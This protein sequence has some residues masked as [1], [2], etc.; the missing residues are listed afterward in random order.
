VDCERASYNTG[1]LVNAGLNH[2][3]K[4]ASNGSKR[5]YVPVLYS[6]WEKKDEFGD[7]LICFGALAI[8]QA[9][10]TEA[11]KKGKVIYGQCHRTRTVSIRPYI[12]RTSNLVDEI[13][14]TC[15]STQPP[16]LILNE[17]CT[18]CDFRAGC[19][20]RAIEQDNLSLLN[21][22]TAKERR[23]CQ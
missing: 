19:R 16:P 8:G 14:S 23:K 4:R 5:A 2:R 18:T 6:P 3:V 22:M 21:G 17:H 13:R 12:A 15:L 20:A 7:L 10:E 1:S 9:N 11:P